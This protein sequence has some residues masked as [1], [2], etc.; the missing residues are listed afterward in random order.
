MRFIHSLQLL[1]SSRWLF[2]FPLPL[3]AQNSIWE[4]K[5]SFWSN[6]NCEAPFKKSC[7]LLFRKPQCNFRNVL[8][9]EM[10]AKFCAGTHSYPPC[11]GLLLGLNRHSW[12]QNWAWTVNSEL[13][14]NINSTQPTQIFGQQK[15]FAWRGSSI[16]SSKGNSSFFSKGQ[17][18]KQR[19]DEAA[20]PL[21]G[22]YQ[23]QTEVI[24][25]LQSL[26]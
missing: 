11:P 21:L 17:G 20:E 23:K 9:K 5:M 25:R 19:G 3:P 24:I 15:V 6:L 18:R 16:P 4:K 1:I 10:E 13:E 2:P 22:F 12:G 7:F 26:L 8:R 14:A